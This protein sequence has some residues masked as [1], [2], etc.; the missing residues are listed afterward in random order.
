MVR[1]DTSQITIYGT[2]RHVTD[3]N[4]TRRMRFEYWITKATETH[5]EYVIRIAYA[6]KQWFR[7]NVRFLRT[8]PCLLCSSLTH[9]SVRRT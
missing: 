9:I 3:Y 8:L 2:A 7:V 5:S 4:I 6:R 1:P